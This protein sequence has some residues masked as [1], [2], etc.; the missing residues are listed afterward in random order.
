MRLAA[1]QSHAEKEAAERD[2]RTRKNRD[3]K[4]KKKQKEKL[5]KSQE[6]QDDGNMADSD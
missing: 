2:K 3:K 1:R 4:I 5:K 6:A